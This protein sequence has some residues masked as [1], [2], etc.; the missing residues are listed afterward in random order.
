MKTIRYL[1]QLNNLKYSPSMVYK[2]LYRKVVEYH[3]WGSYLILYLLFSIYCLLQRPNFK[4]NYR[5]IIF[6]KNY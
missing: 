2:L 4:M 3:R 6:S 5:T 1:F